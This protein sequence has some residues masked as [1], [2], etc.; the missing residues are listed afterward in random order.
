MYGGTGAFFG[1][2]IIFLPL[3]WVLSFTLYTTKSPRLLGHAHFTHFLRSHVTF[4][5]E[6]YFEGGPREL[7][8]LD[9]ALENV[10]RQAAERGAGA[11]GAGAAALIGPLL[12]NLVLSTGK[13][14]E[15]CYCLKAWQSLPTA[16]Q[17]GVYP[18]RDDALK[19][20][21]RP[22]RPCCSCCSTCC[23]CSC[24]RR[25]HSLISV[26]VLVVVLVD[27]ESL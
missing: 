6:V 23:C 19:V 2:N 20:L 18:S 1:A 3:C 15:L 21:S 8:Y 22:F 27:V 11:A 26:L 5:K 9:L 17:A 13:N 7:L 24:R 14:E 16:V 25:H 4:G 12:Q 10:V